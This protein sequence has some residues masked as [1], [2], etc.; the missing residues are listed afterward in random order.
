M[1]L[2]NTITN[3]GRN[4]QNEQRTKEIWDCVVWSALSGPC[5]SIISEI[6][7]CFVQFLLFIFRARGNTPPLSS[8]IGYYLINLS[9]SVCPKGEKTGRPFLGPRLEVARNL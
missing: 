9:L 8:D 4:L 2:T 1:L 7:E 6:N 5:A 3:A